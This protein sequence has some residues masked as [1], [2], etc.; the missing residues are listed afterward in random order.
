MVNLGDVNEALRVENEL[1]PRQSFI[2]MA[3]TA[4]QPW[5]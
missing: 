4:A 1:P 2:H 5:A 3:E